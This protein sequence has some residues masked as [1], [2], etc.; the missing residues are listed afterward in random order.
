M[1]EMDRELASTT[2]GKSFE[3]QPQTATKATMDDFDDVEDFQPVDVDMNAVK[4]MMESFKMQGSSAGPTGN[5]LSTI[6]DG[7][8]GT[9][10]S[11]KKQTDV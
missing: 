8:I 2:I 9:S 1:K 4:N 3:K 6:I 10:S 5:L 7:S 11:S